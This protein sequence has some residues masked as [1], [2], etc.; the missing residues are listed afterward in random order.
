MGVRVDFKDGGQGG[1]PQSRGW[2][3]VGQ[4]SQTVSEGPVVRC[5]SGCSSVPLPWACRLQRPR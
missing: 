5:A 4:P 2:E 3:F 1:R